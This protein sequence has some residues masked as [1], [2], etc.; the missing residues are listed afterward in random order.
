MSLR[1]ENLN[2]Q[3]NE[4]NELF[5]QE[6]YNFQIL[7]NSTRIIPDYKDIRISSFHLSVVKLWLKDDGLHTNNH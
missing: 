4:R 3:K 1:D 5:S 2:P 7:G 6:T